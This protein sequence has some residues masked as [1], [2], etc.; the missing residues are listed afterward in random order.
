MQPAPTVSIAF[1]P[2]AAA[3]LPAHALDLP[4]GLAA[5]GRQQTV[6]GSVNHASHR[7]HSGQCTKKVLSEPSGQSSDV[8]RLP[9]AASARGEDADNHMK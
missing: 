5:C 6:R 9:S 4:T 7:N 1:A 8:R 3:S 2:S